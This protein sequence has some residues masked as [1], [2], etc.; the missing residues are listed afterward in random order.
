MHSTSRLSIEPLALH[1]DAVPVLVSWYEAEWPE[2]YGTGRGDATRDLQSFSNQGSLPVGVLALQDGVV[3]GVAALKAES[4][5]SHK[6]LSPW[7]AAGLVAPAHRGQ[8]IGLQLLLA[9]ESQARALAFTHIYCGTSTAGTL[10]QRAHWQVLE[11]IT[12]EG[13]ALSIYEKA[14]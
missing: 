7:A 10:L 5:P 14:L 6:H 2:W 11:R 12:H 13:K 1:P 3:C 8:G 4:I 9:L